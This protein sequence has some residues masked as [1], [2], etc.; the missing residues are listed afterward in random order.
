[1]SAKPDQLSRNVLKLLDDE[2][3]FLERTEKCVRRIAEQPVGKTFPKS[4]IEELINL[5]NLTVQRVQQRSLLSSEIAKIND[6]RTPS[7]LSELSFGE[8]TD[9]LL[10]EKRGGVLKRAEQ[11]RQDLRILIVQLRESGSVVS[12]VLDFIVGTVTDT[13]RYDANGRPVRHTTFAQ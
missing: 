7:R 11:L 5:H 9:L 12:G 3:T 6:G 8:E 4:L 1:M 10:R 2:D 13:S